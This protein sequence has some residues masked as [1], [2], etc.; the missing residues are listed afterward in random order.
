MANEV[1]A[2]RGHQQHAVMAAYH[3]LEIDRV[4]GHA[5]SIFEVAVVERERKIC[6]RQSGH[7]DRAAHQFVDR[8]GG[9]PRI[10]RAGSKRARY[11][12]DFQR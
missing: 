9:K 7:A 3:A 1:L 5:G 11:D 6:Q 10:Q 4:L 2:I 12:E 8:C